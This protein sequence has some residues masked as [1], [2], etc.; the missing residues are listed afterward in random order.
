M[1]RILVIDDEPYVCEAIQRVLRSRFEIECSAE[2]TAGIE[3][4]GR[5][6]SVDLVI[7][8]LVMPGTDGVTAISRIRKQWPKIRMIAISGGGEHGIADYRPEAIATRA[9]L[10]AAQ[11][12]GADATLAKPFETRE[13]YGVIET[14]MPARAEALTPGD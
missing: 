1:A 14:V 12:A 4:L 2:A 5:T 10:A 9:Y 6:P 7:I 3:R 8:D 11:R 13:L